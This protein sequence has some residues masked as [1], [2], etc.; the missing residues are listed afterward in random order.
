MDAYGQNILPHLNNHNHY[1]QEQ[2]CQ[3]QHQGEQVLHHQGQQVL[4]HQ[5][6][7]VHQHKYKG[8]QVHQHIHN[9][10]YHHHLHL[11]DLLGSISLGNSGD[12]KPTTTASTAAPISAIASNST[13]TTKMGD[14]ILCAEYDSI[15]LRISQLKSAHLD[16]LQAIH[17]PTPAASQQIQPLPAPALKAEQKFFYDVYSVWLTHQNNLRAYSNALERSIH[18]LEERRV[19]IIK[20]LLKAQ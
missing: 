20:G 6:E 10:E 9:G 4:H 12:N 5:G 2:E 11:Q 3:H 16:A 19:E 14:P 8:E 7:Q 1:Y 17:A 15:T 13:S 18:G